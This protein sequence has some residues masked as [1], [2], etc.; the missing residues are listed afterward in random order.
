MELAEEAGMDSDTATI[1]LLDIGLKITS[2]T[3]IIYR[4]DLQTARMALRLPHSPQVTDRCSIRNLSE[5]AGIG[6]NEIRDRLVKEGLLAKRRLKRVPQYTLT[7]VEECLGLRPKPIAPAPQSSVIP[8]KEGRKPKPLWPRV[9]K[10]QDLEYLKPEDVLEFHYV[11]VRDFAKSKN[12]IFMPGPRSRTYLDSAVHRQRTSLGF[13]AKYP[14]V[15][16]AA[17]SLLYGIVLGHP[18]HDGN[19]RTA[20]VAALVFLDKNGWV[21]TCDEDEIYK[22]LLQLADHKVIDSEKGQFELADTEVIEVARWLQ[23][24]IKTVTRREQPLRFRNLKT[25]LEDEGCELE[26]LHGNRINIRRGHLQTQVF[27]QKMGA[28]VDKN[29]IHKIRKDLQLD[30]EHGYDSDIFYNR[31]P[32]IPDFINKYRKLLDKLA[33]V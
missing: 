10:L 29:T 31:G 13:I 9:G 12:P 19:K 20:L 4:H 28:D 2:P 14:T 32:R 24:R 33:K 15:S 26:P 18:F 6:E 27:Y 7:K 25:I 17:A 5:R 22:F 11:L 21:L 16:M 8:K 3:Q 1:Y 23:S 30:E